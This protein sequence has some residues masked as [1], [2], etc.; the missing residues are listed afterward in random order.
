M[1]IKNLIKHGVHD[2][3][4]TSW[5]LSLL[6]PE[7]TELPEFQPRNLL[8]ASKRTKEIFSKNFDEFGDHYTIPSTVEDLEYPFE[9]A[10]KKVKIL[11]RFFFFNFVTNPGN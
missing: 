9:V 4:R 7:A 2:V 5:F 11:E 8:G 3:V 6:T 1:R 10:L